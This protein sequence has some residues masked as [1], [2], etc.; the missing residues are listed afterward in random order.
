MG[1]YLLSQ[2]HT[3]GGELVGIFASAKYG[4]VIRSFWRLRLNLPISG[5]C[6]PAFYW[7]GI[8]LPINRNKSFHLPSPYLDAPNVQGGSAKIDDIGAPDRIVTRRLTFRKRS[9]SK[10]IPR[11]GDEANLNASERRF[12]WRY[13]DRSPT[14]EPRSICR[15]LTM[16]HAAIFGISF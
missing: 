8:I 15:R 2:I 5:I 16:S 7:S 13:P 1:I 10:Q 12:C 11:P 6:R 3:S 4:C 14:R 9:I